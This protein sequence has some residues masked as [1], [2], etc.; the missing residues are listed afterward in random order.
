MAK[1]FLPM[2]LSVAV[3][4][5]TTGCGDGQ[6]R[7]SIVVDPVASTPM[8]LLRCV[9]ENIQPPLTYRWS[10]VGCRTALGGAPLDGPALLVQGAG[11]ER[12]NAT[13]TVATE[14]AA[15]VAAPAPP[16]PAKPKPK[17]APAPA[18]VSRTVELTPPH[19]DHAR[20][21][22]DRLTLD[23]VG[24]GPALQPGNTLLVTGGGLR[25]RAD[26]TCKDASWTD[27]HVVACIAAA[28][29]PKGTPLGVA[30]EV[31]PWLERAALEEV[32]PVTPVTPPAKPR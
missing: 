22:S 3:A 2:L 30:L 9:A 21:R 18:P 13:C 32:T 12:P 11:H 24:F 8:T 10:L 20:R 23:G 16:P 15:N 4:T 14:I 25:W 28:Q 27:R 1:P 26:L 17:A 6:P 7:V 19:I 5:A 29:G 31:D